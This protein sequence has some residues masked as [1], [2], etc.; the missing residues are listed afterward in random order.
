MHIGGS[1]LARGYLNRPELTAEKFI[2]DPFSDEPGARLYKTGDLARFLPDGDIE[3]CG[4]VDDQVKIRGFRVE[5]AEIE[6]ALSEH[7]GVLDC[8]VVA[9]ED[10][11]RSMRLVAYVVP[12]PRSSQ[13]NTA[14]QVRSESSRRSQL[15]VAR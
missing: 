14:Q 10:D 9:R 6:S 2:P 12:R 13:R 5:P 8:V 11:S 7:S 15:A 1:C 3:F 4:R